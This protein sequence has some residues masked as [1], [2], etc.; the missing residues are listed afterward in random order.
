[1]FVVSVLAASLSLPGPGKKTTAEKKRSHPHPPQLRNDVK[2]TFAVK[3][4]L[5]KTTAHIT[6]LISGGFSVPQKNVGAVVD[7]F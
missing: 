2:T 7:P 1:M 5:F 3:R 4:R 6:Q